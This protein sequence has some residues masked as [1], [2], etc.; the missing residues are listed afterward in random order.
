MMNI[1]K[2][3]K[4]PKMAVQDRGPLRSDPHLQWIRGHDCSIDDRDCTYVWG[5]KNAGIEAAHVRS[6]TDGGASSKPSDY[7]S[8]PLCSF[9]HGWQTDHG[10]RAFERKYKINMK[11][12]AAALARQS[13]HLMVVD[14]EIVKR[15]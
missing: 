12:I 2:R 6:G 13:P 10:E 14:G 3:R 11:E 7:W 8:L 15:E 1:P 5:V 9:H 4:A